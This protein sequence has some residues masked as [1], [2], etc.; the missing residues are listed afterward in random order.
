M[1]AHLEEQQELENFKQFWHSKGRWI[2]YLLVLAAIGYFCWTLYQSHQATKNQEAAGI[3]AQIED[4]I[5]AK[6]AFD[7]ELQ[8]LQQNYADTVA[9]AQAVLLIAT[10]EFQQ[11]RYDAAANHLTQLLQKPQQ[12]FIQALATQRLAIVQMQQNQLDNALATLSKPVDPAFEALILET[13]G[14]VLMAQNKNAEAI[15]AYEVAL[16]KLSE[17]AP[18]RD[19]LQLKINQLK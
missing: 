1:A 15:T 18:S 12:P 7:A 5:E 2:F 6:Q 10:H 11:K 9:H 8:N 3:Y 16:T 14:D 4:K 13:K 19:L 17:N